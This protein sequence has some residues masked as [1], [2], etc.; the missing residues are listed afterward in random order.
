MLELNLFLQNIATPFWDNFF[1]FI[2]RLTNEFLY[3]AIVAAIY[4]AIDKKKGLKMAIMVMTNMSLNFLLKD[5]FRI[6]RPYV[7]NKSIINKDI[8]TGYGYSFPSG[9]SQFNSGF[10]SSLAAEFNIRRFYPVIILFVCLV[11]FSRVYL[12]VHSIADVICGV[13]I[14]YLWVRLSNRILDKILNGK[15]YILYLFSL[16]GIFNILIS[17]NIDSAKILLLYLGFIT[18]YALDEKLLCFRI[19]E[20]KRFRLIIFLVFVLGLLIVQLAFSFIEIK[21]INIIKYFVIGIWATF[22]CPFICT[23]K[24]KK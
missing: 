5:I 6:D 1:L 4:Y 21:E 12:G 13:L 20:K 16:I 14:G 7:K 10:Y 17:Q 3:V 2:S 8:E 9:H 19:P 22:I 24:V 15:F 11:A 18:G 23:G